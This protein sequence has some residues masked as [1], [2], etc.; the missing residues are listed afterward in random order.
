MNDLDAIAYSLRNFS[1]DCRE[2]KPTTIKSS[3]YEMSLI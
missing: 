3:E 2:Q 1:S